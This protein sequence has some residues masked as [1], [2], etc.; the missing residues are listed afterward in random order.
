MGG[1]IA[2]GLAKGSIVATNDITVAN[3]SQPKLDALKAE[4]ADINVTHD[5]AA[6]VVGADLIVLAVKPWKIEE[7]IAQIKLSLDYT[8]QQIASVAANVTTDKLAQMLQKDGTTP[9][10][11]I[12]YIIPNTA[13]SVGSSMTF[14]ASRG[15]SAQQEADLKALFDEMGGT[16]FIEERLMGACMALASC[17]IAYAMRYIRASVEGGVELGV[18]PKDALNIVLQTVKGAADLLQATG[19]HPEAEIDKVTTPGG[20]TIKGLNEMERQGF[21]NSVIMGLKAC[22]KN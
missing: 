11:P 21:T 5:N 4:F 13:I 16:L 19:N 18:Y 15:A 14:V 2:R 10:P 7:V 8:R 1:A 9:V 6:A 3:P 17:G 22:V 12:F 20:L